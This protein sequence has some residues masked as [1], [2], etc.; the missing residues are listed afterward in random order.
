MLLL[1]TPPGLRS[2]A[3]RKLFDYL[4]ARRPVFALAEDN[5]AARI[6]AETHAGVCVA[7][8]R[9]DAVANALLRAFSLWQAGRLDQEVPC[10]DNDLYKAETHFTRVLGRIVLPEVLRAKSPLPPERVSGIRHRVP[11]HQPIGVN[12]SRRGGRR[13]RTAATGQPI[14][15]RQAVRPQLLHAAL[16][17]R[18]N[19]S[20]D[21]SPTGWR[22]GCPSGCWNRWDSSGRAPASRSP[23]SPCRSNMRLSVP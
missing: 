13:D 12:D 6:L 18:R 21:A 17:S 9:P 22:P 19:R 3:T 2:I 4:A 8:D 23:R 15:R 1:V 7:P 20:P 10:S 16:R 11:R 14:V 5:E